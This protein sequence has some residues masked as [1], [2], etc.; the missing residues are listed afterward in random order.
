LLWAKDLSFMLLS[1]L[2]LAAQFK[3]FSAIVLIPNPTVAAELPAG[4]QPI[5]VSTAEEFAR[6]FT[7]HLPR[8]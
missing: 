1:Q 4:S 6:A 2:G 3:H 8:E 5:V 7:A